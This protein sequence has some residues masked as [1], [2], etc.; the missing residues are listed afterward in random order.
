MADPTVVHDDRLVGQLRAEDLAVPLEGARGCRRTHEVGR[1]VVAGRRLG[2]GRSWWAWSAPVVGS[3]PRAMASRRRRSAAKA[4]RGRS[5][6]VGGA[7]G[8]ERVS[9]HRRHHLLVG[10][11]EGDAGPD[12]QRL[13]GVDGAAEQLGHLGHREA[14]EVA[15]RERAPRWWAPSRSSTD[16]G[17]GWR[18]PAA[19]HGSS[20]A[21]PRRRRRAPAF[22]SSRARRR[23]WSTSLWRATPISQATVRS[24]TASR[25][26]A[27]TA[28]RKTSAVRSSATPASPQRCSE[29]AEHL[30]QRFVV[31]VEELVAP[32]SPPSLAGPMLR[33]PRSATSSGRGRAPGRATARRGAR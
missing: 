5:G 7:E 33:R 31:E 25:C 15:Q 20:T 8:V 23:Q 18:R 12:E 14:V 6:T 27:S 32:T 1:D 2:R 10:A 21:A 19:S 11:A 13:G 4:R 24:G 28:A 29:V 26:T 17:H 3:S 9:R 16:V 22:R 30:R